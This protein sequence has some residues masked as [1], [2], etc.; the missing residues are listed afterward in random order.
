M[1]VDPRDVWRQFTEDQRCAIADDLA[2]A[3]GR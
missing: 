2:A 1:P 3:S